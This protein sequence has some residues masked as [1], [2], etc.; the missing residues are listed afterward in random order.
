MEYIIV[1]A[2][3]KGSRLEYLTS[4]KPKA[5]V[6]VHNLP[7]LFHLF[8][9]YPDKKYVIIADYKKEVMHEYLEVFA[10]VEYQIVDAEGEGTCGGIQQAVEKIPENK[11]FMLIWSDLILP[12]DFQIPEEF[13]SEVPQNDYIGI[14]ETFPC[15][16]SYKNDLFLEER[17]YE[18]GVAG[19]F[20]FTDKEKLKSVPF[21]GELVKWMKEQNLTFKRKSLAGTKEFGILKEYNELEKEKCRPFNRIT[22]S[23]NFLIKEPLDEQGRNLAKREIDWYRFLSGYQFK[24]I[25]RIHQYEP[26]K[27][28]FIDGRNIYELHDDKEQ[29]RE[30]LNKLIDGLKEIHGYKTVAVDSF[31]MKKAYYQKTMERLSKIRDLVPFARDEFIT[32]NGKKCRNVFFHKRE[33]ENK[34]ENIKCEKFHV[35]HGDCTFSNIMIQKDKEP[36]FIDPRGYFGNT[37]YYGDIRYDW[38][39]LYYSIVGNYDQFNLKNF[40][41]SIDETE[42]HLEIQSNGWE[43]LEKDF[44]ESTGSDEYEIKL[45]HAIIWLSLTTYAWQDYDSICGA[46]YNGLYYLEELW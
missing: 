33:L 2:G 39:K 25:P 16:W 45:I 17:S 29:R 3:G 13:E 32:V 14:S 35:I 8:H 21:N 22:R 34:L 10:S 19:C 7:M 42:V 6:P 12:E 38:A 30:V 41:L 43:D 4:N 28:D 1:Q 9:K 31:S 18:D 20:W 44:F 27:M 36:I 24:N 23:G 5:L 40:R 37:K 15:R 11:A 26:L 46:F